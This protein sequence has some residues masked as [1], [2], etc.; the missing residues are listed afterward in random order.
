MLRRPG[1]LRFMGSQRVGHDWATELNWI[2]TEFYDADGDTKAP[3]IF[4][5]DTKV[6]RVTNTI[7]K[8]IKFQNDH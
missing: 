6:E 7:E 3:V 4:S 2:T 1:V 5:Y 8:S